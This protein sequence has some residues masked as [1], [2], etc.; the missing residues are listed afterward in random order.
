MK[1]PGKWHLARVGLVTAL[2]GLGA[3]WML[4]SRPPAAVLRVPGATEVILR[5]PTWE[6]RRTA[7]EV[8]VEEPGACEVSARFPEGVASGPVRVNLRNTLACRRAGDTL[9]CAPW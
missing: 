4:F 9:E 1:P 2:L 8:H 7:D 5:C 3:G 6:V